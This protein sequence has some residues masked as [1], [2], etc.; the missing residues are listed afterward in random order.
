MRVLRLN[1]CAEL[2]EVGFNIEEDGVVAKI[3]G[4]SYWFECW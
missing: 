1:R 2:R 4:H 3:T